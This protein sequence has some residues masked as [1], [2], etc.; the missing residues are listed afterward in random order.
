VRQAGLQSSDP[1]VV[2]A[3]NMF[4]DIT[5]NF[6]AAMVGGLGVSLSGDIGDVRALFQPSHGS[7][8]DIA[9]PG[10]A[11]PI[12][13]IL[14]T[15]MMLD[16]TGSGISMTT[17]PRR[18]PADRS[19]RLSRESSRPARPARATVHV[20]LA[21]TAGS[22]LFPAAAPGAGQSSPAAI[23]RAWRRRLAMSG[24]AGGLFPPVLFSG[25]R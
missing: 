25:W 8:R 13:M 3:E 18:S 20:A 12:G 2:V 1:D 22:L 9:G 21:V 4:G 24:A 6:G 11:N 16:S 17:R 10:I 14:S 23:A 7:A 5:S 19:M 15:A